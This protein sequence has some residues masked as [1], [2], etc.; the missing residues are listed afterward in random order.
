MSACP[1]NAQD[2]TASR[3]KEK[4]KCLTSLLSKVSGSTAKVLLRL[5]LPEPL[6]NR[7]RTNLDGRIEKMRYVSVHAV[8][9]N[10]AVELPAVCYFEYDSEVL[11]LFVVM[12]E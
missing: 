2:G 12:P 4:E 5:A 10:H 9:N 8:R 11:Y 3:G 6:V 1:K 7:Q